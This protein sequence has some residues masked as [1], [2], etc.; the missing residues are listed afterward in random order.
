M[1]LLRETTLAISDGDAVEL[2]TSLVRGTDVKNTVDINIKGNFNLRG[3]TR[4]RRN[5]RQLKLAKQV[6]L[7]A[8]LLF[9]VN[10]NKYTRLVVRVS[11]EYFGLLVRTV[12]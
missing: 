9:F 8:S 10:L 12:E 3:T 2:S 1:N 4:C 11:G 5:A 7:R 6:V